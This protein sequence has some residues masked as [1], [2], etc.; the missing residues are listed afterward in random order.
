MN[1][2][3]H[4]QKSAQILIVILALLSFQRL[5]AQTAM[6]PIPLQFGPWDRVASF[7]VSQTE[8]YIILCMT[9]QQDKGMLFESKFENGTWTEPKPIDAI[10]KKYG[11][12]FDISGP[13]LSAND[14]EL[15]FHANFPDSKGG[16]DLYCSQRTGNAWSEP[17]N[18]GEP[19][20]SAYDEVFPSMAPGNCRIFFSRLKPSESIKKPDDQPTCQ[21]LFQSYRRPLGNGW[22]QPLILHEFINRYCENAMS[23]A[24]DGVTVLFS[25]IDPITYKEGYRVCFTRELMR[26]AWLLPTPVQMAPSDEPCLKPQVVN[27]SIYFLRTWRKKKINYGSLFKVEAPEAVRP[28]A[29]LVSSGKISSLERGMALNADLTVYK[30]ET[31]QVLGRYTSDATTGEYSIPLLDG[32]NY[33]VEVR[34]EGYS[35]ATFTVEYRS[36]EKKSGPASIVLFKQIEL[37]LNVYDSEIFRPL[38]STVWVENSTKPGVKIE[39]KMVEPG[40]YS[41]VLPIGNEYKAV[42]SSKKFNDNTF[43]LNLKGDVVF[44]LFERNLPISPKKRNL[45]LMVIDSETGVGL[46]SNLT[47]KNLNRDET[48]TVTPEKMNLGQAA[49]TLREGDKYDITVRGPQ[50]YSFSNQIVDLNSFTENTLA[51]KLVT[52][53]TTTAI[54]L[55]NINFA[56][57]SVELSS[58]SF[59][60]LDRVVTLLKENPSMVIEIAAHTDNEGSDQQNLLLS[61]RR[62]QSVVNYL[63][64]TGIT[65]E[66]LVAKGYGLRNPLVP[67]TTDANKALN[68]RVEFK[69]IEI[70]K[71]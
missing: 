36:K 60:E 33:L 11:E 69:I 21:T 12:G 13:S 57:N 67:N 4:F 71:M 18:M 14:K 48:I 62:A 59:P 46:S 10:N 66:H 64:E 20:N 19:L 52:L 28:L 42:A 68:R 58:E 27:N 47:L 41:F 53:K 30:P 25:S 37:R 32:Q 17:V 3:F 35:F 45:S 16:Y 2:Y 8:T 6:P 65:P 43:M 50:G 26:D 63:I 38:E 1:Q 9:N 54:Q 23:V 22:D 55:N 31:M 39:G 7:S 61:E 51:I 56:S 15:Y 44:P 49:L 29:T 5:T 24:I 70:N 40:I 34:R